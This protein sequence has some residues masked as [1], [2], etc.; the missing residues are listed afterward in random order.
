M[1]VGFLN[2]IN[3]TTGPGNYGYHIVKELIDLNVDVVPITFGN[4][5]N[6]FDNIENI[7]IPIPTSNRYIAMM[8]YP[9]IS[10][11]YL[12]NN[13]FDILH[14]SGT[15]YLGP[16]VLTLHEV[17]KGMIKSRDYWRI[18]RYLPWESSILYYE[19]RNLNDP[20]IKKIKCLSIG[21]KNEIIKY[22]N[23]NEEK[24]AVIPNGVDLNEFRPD[25]HKRAEIREELGFDNNEMI[26]MFSAN[27]YKRK[28]L[29]YIIKSLPDIPNNIKLLVVGKDNPL[30]YKKLASS[31]GVTSRVVFSGFVPDIKSYYLAS[32]V[33]IFPTS[34]EA[35][36]LATL[37]A[38]S[39]GLP[40]LATKVNGTEELIQ[41]W[42][43]GFFIK[44]E[45]K[46]I[47]DKINI[48]NQD[49]NLMRSM[50][51][52]ARKTAKNYSWKNAAEKT[53][54]LYKDILNI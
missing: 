8:I 43:N 1:K 47:A 51:L 22:Y 41:D 3:R 2:P 33:F 16:D 53:L 13:D 20:D 6:M 45:K 37:E 26:L 38:I 15:Y 10:N 5:N 28:G 19:R 27:E 29:D 21:E 30:P 44:R 36:S 34:Y 52:N 54:K 46:D 14:S 40:I 42:Y 7:Q 39:C 48:I 23:V 35:F 49:E 17:H 50:S 32:D 24:I 25:S 31:L 9:I 18:K 12:K 11:K 4:Y